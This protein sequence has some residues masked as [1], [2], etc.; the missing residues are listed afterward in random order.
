[1]TKVIL[2]FFQL[3]SWSV[4]KSASHELRNN[5][6]LGPTLSLFLRGRVCI[7]SLGFI[8]SRL[9]HVGGWAGGLLSLTH[10]GFIYLVCNQAL[11][12]VTLNLLWNVGGEEK[13]NILHET[14]A[15]Q[16]ADRRQIETKSSEKRDFGIHYILRLNCSIYKIISDVVMDT[17]TISDKSRTAS[18]LRLPNPRPD[19]YI[20]NIPLDTPGIR[21]NILDLISETIN[22]CLKHSTVNQTYLLEF[23]TKIPSFLCWKNIIVCIK[24]HTSMKIQIMAIMSVCRRFKFKRL[25]VGL[26]MLGRIFNL[27]HRL[28]IKMSINFN[29]LL[30]VDE[31]IE[32]GTLR[33]ALRDLLGRSHSQAQNSSIQRL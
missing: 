25:P 14:G 32:T 9:Q 13:I 17:G 3:T 11:G 7:H 21:S 31:K 28:L 2:H 22:L 24:S 27:L 16:A 6:M 20:Q 19:V 18:S 29:L 26:G 10:L 4:V 8:L 12:A 23:L 1:M 33:L 5:S 30:S 15:Q